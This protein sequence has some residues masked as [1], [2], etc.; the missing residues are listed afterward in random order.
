MFCLIFRLNSDFLERVLFIF[1]LILVSSRVAWNSN[2]SS[3][4]L[5]F[6]EHGPLYNHNMLVE[7]ILDASQKYCDIWKKAKNTKLMICFLKMMM[8]PWNFYHDLYS[9]I[10]NLVAA[11]LNL[12]T[13]FKCQPPFTTRKYLIFFN[14]FLL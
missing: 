1:S 7:V 12:Y 6:F 9:S 10:A 2:L 3:A 5:Y 14:F 4:A 11:S 13:F 8:E